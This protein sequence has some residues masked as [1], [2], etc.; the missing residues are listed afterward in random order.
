[1]SPEQ[2]LGRPIGAPSDVFSLGVLLFEMLRQASRH[3]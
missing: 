3:R 2:L 1:M